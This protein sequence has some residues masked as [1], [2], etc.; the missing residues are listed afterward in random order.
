[1]G[2]VRQDAGDY[3]Y[4]VDSNVAPASKINAIATRSLGL[5]VVDRLGRP[6]SEH[7]GRDLAEPDRRR[8]RPATIASC[9][10]WKTSR[11]LGMY[12]RVLAPESSRI[13]SVSGGS[14][15]ELTAPAVVGEE[16]GR[17]EIGTYLMVPP[18]TTSLRYVWTSPDVGRSDGSGGSYRLTIQKQPG[19]LPGPLTLYD[20]RA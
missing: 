20:P 11:I 10:R 18:G 14:V 12:F 4:P 9:R 17:A 5:E 13:E 15:V 16:A 2:H 8:G 7:P 19:L 3:V 6:R 1:M